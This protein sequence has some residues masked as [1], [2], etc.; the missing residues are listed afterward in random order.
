M[1]VQPLASPEKPSVHL[2]P[3][4]FPPFPHATPKI[5]NTSNTRVRTT[6]RGYTSHKN[7]EAL[8][9]SANLS[10]TM[11]PPHTAACARP[12]RRHRRLSCASL[13]SLAAVALLAG[14]VP[15]FGKGGGGGGG[16]GLG[17][18]SSSMFAEAAPRLPHPGGDSCWFPQFE[19]FRSTVTPYAE[20]CARS[21]AVTT[22]TCQGATVHVKAL[23][24][25][26]SVIDVQVGTI[27]GVSFC[28]NKS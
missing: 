5:Q 24:I 12:F 3:T 16:A 6:A 23:G 1:C 14:W 10:A 13:P 28:T 21:F 22:G 15:P 2:T 26:S 11:A 9:S 8:H 4:Y 17:L 7:Y 19:A 25:Y 18:L 27:M 20:A